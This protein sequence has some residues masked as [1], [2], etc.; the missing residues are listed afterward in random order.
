MENMTLYDVFAQINDYFATVGQHKL[1]I[2]QLIGDLGEM[3]FIYMLQGH[4]IDYQKYY[5]KTEESLYDFNIDNKYIDVKTTSVK[6]KVITLTYRQLSTQ[7][8]IIFYCV[9][10]NKL[11]GQSN[12]NDI[13]K[14]IRE[15]NAYVRELEA[16]WD[17]LYKLNPRIVDSWTVNIKDIVSFKVDPNQIP[18]IKVV[19]AGG[20]HEMKIEVDVTAGNH[21]S[22]DEF[23][24]ELFPR[25]IK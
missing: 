18:I 16:K 2:K 17:I 25:E 8:K 6:R 15:K 23:M 13:I 4:N 21:S 5:Q 11:E 19:E 9:E 7:Q 24:K 3:L 14:L 20:L 1:L 12:I 22:F 10:I